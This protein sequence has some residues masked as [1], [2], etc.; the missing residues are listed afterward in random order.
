MKENTIEMLFCIF[1]PPQRKFLSMIP[2]T[3]QYHVPVYVV[4]CEPLRDERFGPKIL[5]YGLPGDP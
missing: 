1:M 5:K 3:G 2:W 4:D